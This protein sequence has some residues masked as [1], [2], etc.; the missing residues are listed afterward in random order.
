M[1]VSSLR[2]QRA[3]EAVDRYARTGEV[4][5]VPAYKDGDDRAGMYFA[6]DYYA[7]PRERRHPGVDGTRWRR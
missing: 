4:T 6:L 7:R 5:M 2:L 1:L 3:R